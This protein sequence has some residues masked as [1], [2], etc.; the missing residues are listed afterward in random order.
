MGRMRARD[1][2]IT[3]RLVLHSLSPEARVTSCEASHNI[4]L[5]SSELGVQSRLQQTVIPG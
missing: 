5:V 2:E 4:V 3:E 1:K